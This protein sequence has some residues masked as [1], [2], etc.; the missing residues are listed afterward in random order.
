MADRFFSQEGKLRTSLNRDTE[1]NRI[2]SSLTGAQNNLTR[3]A[4]SGSLQV[5]PVPT[6][7]YASVFQHVAEM[8]QEASARGDTAWLTDMEQVLRLVVPEY[9]RQPEETLGLL[10]FALR[11]SWR[12]AEE[13]NGRKMT[14]GQRID[15]LV[16]SVRGAVGRFEKWA[17]RQ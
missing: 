3:Q 6:V 4:Q 10:L 12:Q 2:V 5:I 1:A 16:Q 13:M 17:K 15:S 11:S 7:L 14:V 9:A 8:T